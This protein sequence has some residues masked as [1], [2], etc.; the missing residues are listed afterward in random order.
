MK[1]KNI[2][3]NLRR[4]L[5]WG[6]GAVL[7]FTTIGFVEQQQQ[8]VQVVNINI[9]IHDQFEN[10][11]LNDQDIMLL[12]TDG[13]LEP[14]TG[15][16]YGDLDL[17]K[18]EE[19]VE[20]HKFIRYAEVSKDL[21][22]NLRVDAWQARPIARL[23]RADGIDAYISSEGVILPVLDRY[24]A[25]T[26]LIS[27]T[28]SDSLIRNDLDEE[29]YPE[30]LSLLQKLD[31]DP[32]WKAQIAQLEVNTDQNIR[33]YPQVTRQTIEF[34]EPTD[35]D[36]KLNKLRIFYRRILPAKGWNTYSRVNLMYKDQI[37]CE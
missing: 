35:I 22:G 1:W 6:I 37:I 5:V 21:R 12:M 10:F 7:L 19:R 3:R 32:F 2:D 4:A 23:I 33:M 9:S 31:A 17:K 14:V 29:H 11:F 25:R 18:L 34:G 36:T 26:V 28:L 13:G 27:G 24:T 20:K 16:P 15:A 8:A 30:I